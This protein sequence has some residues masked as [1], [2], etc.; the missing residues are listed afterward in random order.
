MV[1]RVRK[2]KID[3]KKCEETDELTES[4]NEFEENNYSPYKANDEKGKKWMKR[5]TRRRITKERKQG[6]NWMKGRTRRT[7]GKRTI[8]RRKEINEEYN[9]HGE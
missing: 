9:K 2:G 4:W 8:K 5:I 3:V 7:V 6:W 1:R